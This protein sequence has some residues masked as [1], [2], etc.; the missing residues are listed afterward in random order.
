[1]ATTHAPSKKR[2]GTT[3][4]HTKDDALDRREFEHLLEAT[5]ALDDYYGL[6]AQFVV[7]VAGRLGLRAGEI[8][9]M[10]A[11]WVDWRRNMISIP[12]HEPCTK[13]RDG[14]L[15]G[16]CRSKAEQKVAHNDGLALED[17]LASMWSPKTI[18][19]SREIP[20]DA[21]PRA[22][23]VIE[24]FFE[25]FDEWPTSRQSVNRR[26]NRAAREADG[27]DE[28]DVYPHALRATAAS[29]FA[30]RGL[31]IFAL[32]AVMG[33][34]QIST[35]ECYVSSSGERTAQAIRDTL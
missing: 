30:A 1:M 27:L 35:A 33:W 17:A 21:A 28:A 9:H 15:C 29:R 34:S 4:R 18:S 6:Q 19:S 13:G 24:R 12:R 20:F 5:Y 26:V 10:T 8:A 23:I 7:L 31:D 22:E 32:K 25:R 16:Y 3:V 2:R 11:E 14:G